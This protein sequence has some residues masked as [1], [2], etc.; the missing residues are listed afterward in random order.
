LMLGP[1]AKA[2]PNQHMAQAG[3]SRAA[4]RNERMA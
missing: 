4:S 2:T 3:S 1:S